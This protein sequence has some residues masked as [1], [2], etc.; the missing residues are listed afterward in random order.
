MTSYVYDPVASTI[1]GEPRGTSPGAPVDRR[2]RRRGRGAL[3]LDPAEPGRSLL[4]GIVLGIDGCFRVY[5]DE[6]TGARSGPERCPVD[7]YR[8]AR[9]SERFAAELREAVRADL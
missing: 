9:C 3:S 2:R 7:R 4:E 6:L 5:L 8:V 1:V